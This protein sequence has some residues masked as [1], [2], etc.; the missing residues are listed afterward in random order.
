MHTIMLR[1]RVSKVSSGTNYSIEV[2]GDSAAKESVQESIRALEHHPARAAR[3][4]LIDLMGLI[5]K[6][7]FRIAH[8]EHDAEE[9]TWTFFLQG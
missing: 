8:A 5:E 9:D 7:N 1:N 3:R 6:H 2:I 4:S